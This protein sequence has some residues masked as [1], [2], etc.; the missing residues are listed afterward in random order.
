MR[1]L[2][3]ETFYDRFYDWAESTQISNIS[4]LEN[5]GPSSEV[6]EIALDFMDEKIATRFVK[7][8]L[9]AGVRF[10]AEEVV[11]LDGSVSETL[12]LELA[13][14]ASTPFT[15][16][17]LDTIS[18]SLSEQDLKT[19]AKKNGLEL[20]ED[21]CVIPEPNEMDAQVDQMLKDLDFIEEKLGTF[22]NAVEPHAPKPGFGQMML[23][24]FSAR[25][26]SIP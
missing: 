10:T 20:D 19:I 17:D 5:F 13:K 21:N 7:K 22:Q 8:A 24:L 6:C 16:D 9:A 15:A 26:G 4:K 23:L 11:E 25:H 1:G 12:F 18:L 2:T 3:W 14:T